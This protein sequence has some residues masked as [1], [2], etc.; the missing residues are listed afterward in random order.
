MRTVTLDSAVD[1]DVLARDIYVNDVYLFGAGT[2]L[3]R[4][5]I[6]I[7]HELEVTHLSIEDRE[8]LGRSLKEQFTSL[9]ARFSATDDEPIMQ[10]LKG[11]IKDYLSNERT[12]AK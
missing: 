4:Q 3:N 11:W 6:G 12:D 1:G 8:H 10:H 7:L 5:R 9:D 2:V